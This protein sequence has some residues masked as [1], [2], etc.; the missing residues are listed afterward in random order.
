MLRLE[1]VVAGA[2]ARQD[3]VFAA[4]RA[5]LETQIHSLEAQLASTQSLLEKTATSSSSPSSASSP[6]KE[7]ESLRALRESAR[8]AGR[9][10]QELQNA[11]QDSESALEESTARVVQLEEVV[12]ER[13][14]QVETLEREVEGVRGMW[15]EERRGW[16]KREGKLKALVR[17]LKRQLKSPPSTP[18]TPH[19]TTPSTPS[20]P[21][22]S[23]QACGLC[24]ERKAQVAE[25]E[26]IIQQLEAVL[27]KQRRRFLAQHDALASKLL[28]LKS[29]HSSP[30]VLTDVIDALQDEVTFLSNAN[31][32]MSR[33]PNRSRSASVDLEESRAW[34]EEKQAYAQQMEQVLDENRALH[35]R[36]D[37]L[38]HAL[39]LSRRTP[40]LSPTR[41]LHMSDLE[42]REASSVSPSSSSPR[43]SMARTSALERKVDLL[44]RTVEDTR[45]S[46]SVQLL[47]LTRAYEASLASQKEA[48]EASLAAADEMA[49]SHQRESASEIEGLLAQVATLE[50]QLMEERGRSRAALISDAG[51]KRPP[52]P[53]QHDRH[54]PS[55]SPDRDQAQTPTPSQV[56]EMVLHLRARAQEIRRLR[57]ALEVAKADKERALD[58]AATRYQRMR[59]AA[60]AEAESWAHAKQALLTEIALLRER[61]ASMSQT[62][63][64]TQDRIRSLSS[65]SAKESSPPPDSSDESSQA[66]I[67]RFSSLADEWR[68][69]YLEL[70]MS[71]DPDTL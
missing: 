29:A 4:E 8:E 15:E 60:S 44:K 54:H 11:L 59:A 36:I 33:Q 49:S 2:L 24:E 28:S 21:H 69:K 46:A 12:E 70:A 14:G 42:S 9:I 39:E 19:P 71:I 62:L 45:R 50:E 3:S 26:F 67:L 58:A 52:N 22:P 40:P 41:T 53:D 32:E 23:A 65:S 68:K 20:T 38:D 7:E 16:R 56:R 43:L 18:S 37:K 47:D 10:C 55:S 13:N 30:G 35:A 57:D 61:E 34:E 48:A 51:G 25:D 64:M 63:R 17:K 1:D 27:I 6:R 66:A 5:E 31:V